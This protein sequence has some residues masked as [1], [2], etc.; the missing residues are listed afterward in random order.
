M[1][2]SNIIAG[3]FHFEKEK[4]VILR[5]I[6]GDGKRVVHVAVQIF[7]LEVAIFQGHV[8]VRRILLR[9]RHRAGIEIGKSLSKGRCGQH[10]GVS[11]DEQIA[12]LKH[13]CAAGVVDIVIYSQKS[14]VRG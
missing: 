3:L 11:V 7:P 9:D 12:L 1:V 5:S 8:S 14:A 13:S 10:V 2:P 6:L 4:F